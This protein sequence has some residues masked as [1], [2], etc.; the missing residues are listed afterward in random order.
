MRY[1]QER[2]GCLIEGK[3]SGGERG[4]EEDLDLRESYREG[5]FCKKLGKVIGREYWDEERF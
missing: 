2:E 1:V 4:G 5:I 3:G